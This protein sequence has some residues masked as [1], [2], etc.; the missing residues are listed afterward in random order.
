LFGSVGKKGETFMDRGPSRGKVT[1]ESLIKSDCNII[2]SGTVARREKVLQAGLFDEEL[3]RIGMEDFD[4]WLRL[5]KNGARLDYQRKVLLKYRVR[6][7]SLSGSNVQ[8]AERGV[9]A[10][11]IIERKLDLND[12]ESRTLKK[13]KELAGAELELEKG[14]FHLTQEN[15]EAARLHF[16]RAN[17]YYR[18][19]KLEVVL[20]LLKVYPRLALALFKKFRAS[21]FLFINPQG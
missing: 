13:Q 10:L 3:P 9:K 6:P 15:Y 16:H 14:K 4:L 11:E 20:W 8:R 12:A 7:N 21:D 1:A 5:A 19:I 2:T 18:K 17:E